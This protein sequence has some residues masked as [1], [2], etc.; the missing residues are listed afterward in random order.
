MNSLRQWS[1]GD[2]STTVT[3]PLLVT[4]N[5]DFLEL[6][7]GS[8]VSARHREYS[9]RVHQVGQ[10]LAEGLKVLVVLPRERGGPVLAHEDDGYR[11]YRSGL[12]P[13]LRHA[14]LKEFQFGNRPLVMAGSPF[15]DGLLARRI[16]RRWSVPLQVQCHGEFGSPA[17]PNSARRR[18]MFLLASKVLP[19]AT[20]VRCVSEPQAQEI[21]LTFRVDSRRTFAAPVP[22][23]Q[24]F[25]RDVEAIPNDSSSPAAFFVGRFHEERGLSAWAEAANLIHRERPDVRFHIVGSGPQRSR[26]ERVIANCIPPDLATW[27]GHL[28]PPSLAALLL[29]EEGVLL[30]TAPLESLGRS[31]IESVVCGMPVV[32]RDTAGSR[33][34]EALLPGITRVN[35]GTPEIMAKATLESLERSPMWEINEVRQVWRRHQEEGLDRLVRSWIYGCSP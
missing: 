20:C 16:A 6:P 31:M 26:F 3:E 35:V 23:D 33:A 11:V 27:H 5:K 10:G 22:V 7:E 8:G 17:W 34:L 18:S 14:P 12:A 13:L 19:T 30:N 32:A 29:S 9:Q 28:E 1:R 21:T 24:E 4:F 15:H 25:L 2:V